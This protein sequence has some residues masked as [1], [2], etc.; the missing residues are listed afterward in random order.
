MGERIFTLTPPLSP[1]GDL[2]THLTPGVEDGIKGSCMFT[3]DIL[4]DPLWIG[5]E[6]LSEQSHPFRSAICRDGFASGSIGGLP[7]AGFKT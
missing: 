7:M 1:Q 4:A 5:F 2:S 6:K 3:V